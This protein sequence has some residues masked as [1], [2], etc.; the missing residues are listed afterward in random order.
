MRT[1]V[2]F[3][4]DTET[5]RDLIR[6]LDRQQ[7]RQ[8]SAAIR[9]ALRAGVGRQEVTIADVLA[10]IEG[11]RASGVVVAAPVAAAADDEPADVAVALDR[12]GL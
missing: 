4:L 10:A 8:R 7:G 3:S 11:L 12:L 2:T 9:A 1:T 5:D 6:W